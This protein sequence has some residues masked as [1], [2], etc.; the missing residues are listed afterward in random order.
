MPRASHCWKEPESPSGGKTERSACPSAW[1]AT[2]AMVTRGLRTGRPLKGGPTEA[3]V[4]ISEQ[5]ETPCLAGGGACC[6]EHSNLRA[7]LPAPAP[8]RPCSPTRGSGAHSGGPRSP[9]LSNG[10]AD[11]RSGELRRRGVSQRPEGPASIGD[12][13]HRPHGHLHPGPPR[14]GPLPAGRTVQPDARTGPRAALR[15]ACCVVLS[16]EGGAA[17]PAHALIS[18]GTGTERARVPSP[19]VCP[20]L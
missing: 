1:W 7:R 4:Q 16:P 19:G 6:R 12:H 11:G 2:V 13:C 14:T 17:Y 5:T 10:R 15:S 8:R 20:G 9:H 3:R 18:Q